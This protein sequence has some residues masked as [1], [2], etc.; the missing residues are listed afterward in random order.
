MILSTLD[1]HGDLRASTVWPSNFLM[2]PLNNSPW[3]ATIWAGSWLV[4]Y[5][6]GQIKESYWKAELILA[7]GSN[8]SQIATCFGDLPVSNWNVVMNFLCRSNVT[9]C[10]S[11]GQTDRRRG[12]VRLVALG[13]GRSPTGSTLDLYSVE[14][15]GDDVLSRVQSIIFRATVCFVAGGNTTAGFWLWGSDSKSICPKLI[16]T[17]TKA[18]F[19][20]MK[21]AKFYLT[22][23]Y[24][25]YLCLYRYKVIYILYL[26]IF[27]I[28]ESSFGHWFKAGFCLSDYMS[29]YVPTSEETIRAQTKSHLS[30]ISHSEQ[31]LLL[32]THV[33]PLCAL[34][35]HDKLHDC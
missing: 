29:F 14:L 24:C 23:L 16:C 20:A 34:T 35:L 3:Q 4:Q 22:V 26:S 7:T 21:L 33:L 31:P 9:C 6:K 1:N 18:H 15:S 8:S 32:R 25:I 10:L 13:R 5:P 11:K 27:K 2:K 12:G 30:V 28:V 17:H 19:S